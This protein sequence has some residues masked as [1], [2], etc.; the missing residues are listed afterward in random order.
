MKK[1]KNIW[2]ILAVILILFLVVGAFYWWQYRP[3]Q[4]RKE[5]S[6]KYS[7]TIRVTKPDNRSIWGTGSETSTN[8]YQNCLHQNGLKQ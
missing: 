2:K 7:D 5:C 3:A 1:F 6:S 8:Q 4:I